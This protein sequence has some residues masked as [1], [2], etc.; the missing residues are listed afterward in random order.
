MFDEQESCLE[1]TDQFLWENMAL[2][3]GLGSSK[4]QRE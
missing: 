4:K 3:Y 1:L 2:A